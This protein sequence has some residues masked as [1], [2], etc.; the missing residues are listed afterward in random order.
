MGF[1]LE[2]VEMDG[3]RAGKFHLL[4]LYFI[5]VLSWKGIRGDDWTLQPQRKQKFQRG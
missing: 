2:G 1:L 5:E 3:E 4:P